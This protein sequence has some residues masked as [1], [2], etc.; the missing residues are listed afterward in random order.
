MATCTNKEG[1]HE[2][3]V[4]LA[5]S[6]SSVF[7]VHNRPHLMNRARLSSSESSSGFG[8]EWGRR[9]VIGL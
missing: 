2:S 3:T 9:R 8:T 4:N 6:S 5:T 1:N 7:C